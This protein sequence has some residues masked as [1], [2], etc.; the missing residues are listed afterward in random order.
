[1]KRLREDLGYAKDIL[2]SHGMLSEL[3]VGAP[4]GPVARAGVRLLEWHEQVLAKSKR[5]LRKRLDQLSRAEPF[6]RARETADFR[7]ER[8]GT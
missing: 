3:F 5:M 2:V 8:V 1:M 7:S 6:W 4:R